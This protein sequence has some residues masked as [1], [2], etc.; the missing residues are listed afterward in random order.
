[1][2]NS[3]TTQ[4]R[5]QQLESELNRFVR[6]LSAD[7]NVQ[8]VIVFGSLASGEMHEWSDIDLAV[9]RETSLKFFKRLK[10]EYATLQPEVEADILVY[11]P[12]EYREMSE[13]RRFVH[14]EIFA[15]GKVIYERNGG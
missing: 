11:T 1:M 15:K 13:N 2:I 4:T 6:I 8:K 7:E 14:D 10:Q 3:I 9:V 5:I 12:S